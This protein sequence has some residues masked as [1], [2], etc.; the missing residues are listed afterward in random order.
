M[1]E[2]CLICKAPLKY[3]NLDEV[4]MC[5]ICRQTKNTK[6]K[7]I[8]NHFVCDECHTNGIHAILSICFRSSSR[9]PIEIME[10][11]MSMPSCHMHGP[12]H[13][14][15]VGS[16]LLTAYKNAKGDRNRNPEL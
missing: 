6:T 4:M 13:H 8:N 7:R 11:M 3:L 10:E 16:A 5:E 1:N 12:E 14:I 15:M 9:N 2:E